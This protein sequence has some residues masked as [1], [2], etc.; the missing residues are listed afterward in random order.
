M[1]PLVIL[2]II[3]VIIS[4]DFFFEQSLDFLNLKAQK[5]VIPEEM[6]DFYK[7]DKY[8][9]SMEYQRVQTRFSFITSTFSFILS[10]CLLYFGFFGWLDGQVATMVDGEI[11]QAMAFFGILFFASDIVNTP[12]GAYSTFVIEEKFGFNKTTLKT[13][14]GDKLKGYLLTILIG[15]VLGWL[16]LYL[17]F[18]LG[19]SFWIYFLGV[20]GVFMLFMNMFYTTLILPL[21]NKLTPLEDGELKTAIEEYCRKEN[22]PISNIFVIDGSRRSKKSNAF[23]SGLGKKKKIVLY[24]TLIENHSKEELVAIF[25]HEIGHFKKKH[26][27][28]G[29]VLSILQVAITLLILS[30]MIFNSNLSLALGGERMA[31]HLNLLAFGILYS[32]ISHITGLLMMILSRKNEF[33]ADAYATQTYDGKALQTALKKLSVDNLSNLYP[34]RLYVFFHYS[35]PPLL[36]RLSAID[37]RTIES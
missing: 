11:W 33:E 9:K 10:F 5:D 16:F 7:E 23:F 36:R 37:Q 25:A 6:K 31:V 35:H 14:I 28:Q 15:G 3:L 32:P 24:D 21:F 1:D 30:L 8:K 19:A 22:F 27:L 13:F 20:I 26:I 4:V 18:N 29:Y 12:F 34:H 17:V 2:I